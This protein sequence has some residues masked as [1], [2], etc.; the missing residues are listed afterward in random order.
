MHPIKLLAK[1]TPKTSNIGAVGGGS[2]V[3]VID[4]RDASHSLVGL[5]QDAYSWALYRF[6]GHD[7]KE[8]TIIRTLTMTVT[9]LIKI[10]RF[11]IKP[12]T[13]DGIVRAAILEFTQPVCGE[14][15][16]SGWVTDHLGLKECPP[17][18]GKGRKTISKRERCRV[19][20]IK[21]NSYADSH[22]EI[23]KELLNIISKWEQLII[24]NV[25]DKM[26][27]VA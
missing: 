1:M 26:G 13:L 4:W 25:N 16:G 27:E 22:D 19:I 6:A 18:H 15:H 21:P 24:K 8:R 9:L 11:K 17:C 7:E 12:D 23:S 2:S 10:R 3:D 5:Q 20:G 14:C